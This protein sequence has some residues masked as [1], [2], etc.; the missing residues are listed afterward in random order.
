MFNREARESFQ[1]KINQLESVG[2]KGRYS[3]KVDTFH[4]FAFKIIL[5]AQK[6][7]LVSGANTPKDLDERVYNI[8]HGVLM[9]MK[10]EGHFKGQNVGEKVE[11]FLGVIGLLKGSCINPESAGCSIVEYESA[12]K[13][14]EAQR[15]G[16]GI[17]SYD[18][19][20]PKAIELI[21][22]SQPIAQDCLGH[23]QH[24]LV[25][26]YQDVNFGQQR[27]I[28]SIV[29]ISK[30]D[31]MVVG[32]DDQTIY[33]WRGARPVYILDGF[34][35][36]FSDKPSITY[37]LTNTFRFAPLLSQ[38][39]ANVIYNNK[40]REQKEVV[41]MVTDGHTQVTLMSSGDS[42]DYKEVCGDIISQLKARSVKP[43]D[44]AVLCAAYNQL[45]A[46]QFVFKEKK[47]PFYVKGDVSLFQ[48]N[49]VQNVFN[50]I[51]L[52][53]R[54]DAPILPKDHEFISGLIRSTIFFPTRYV[55]S[56][57]LADANGDAADQKTPRQIIEAMRQNLS[58]DTAR[59][60]VLKNV[61]EYLSLLTG[62]KAR[63]AQGADL[64]SLLSEVVDGAKIEDFFEKYYGDSEAS[65]FRM[66]TIR[67]LLSHV[68][69]RQGDPLVILDELR[70]YDTKLGRQEWDC[71]IMTSIHKTKGLEWK[72][73]VMPECN[74][75]TIPGK[76][77]PEIKIWDK[78]GSVPEQA[79]SP[80]V[81]SQRRLFYVGITRARDH[82]YIFSNPP[83]PMGVI[84]W[85]E[86][87]QSRFVGEM[88]LS[89]AGRLFRSFRAAIVQQTKE[90]LKDLVASFSDVKGC[91]PM[92]DM[93]VSRYLGAISD[94]GTREEIGG[95][96]DAHQRQPVVSTRDRSETDEEWFDKL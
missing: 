75:G 78:K 3:V 64:H 32:D 25:D 28:E 76:C 69:G 7:G 11:E 63:L 37:K 74:E 40:G 33:E 4:S 43:A 87:V 17:M 35:D 72:I 49:E 56:S 1:E 57:D 42:S 44:V 8:A 82:L 13:L 2:G 45:M 15:L 71:I 14:F 79:L 10:K 29:A 66:K 5:A 86:G 62:L 24:L 81:E 48:K 27:L 31:V 30:P 6:A 88:M 96:H 18:D 90:S 22:A 89:E 20:V 93:F 67:A 91:A 80:H 77:F 95:I 26:E 16:K 39:A 73:V 38:L 70:N 36:A 34:Q 68:A 52:A 23:I 61:E 19:Y 60:Y 84:G 83:K 55:K 12:Y 59:D 85:P 9:K 47:I 51:D 54:L 92:A 50:Y 41:S 46:I 53:A 94:A 21:G 58:K 65:G